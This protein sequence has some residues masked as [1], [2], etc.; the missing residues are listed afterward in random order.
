[1]RDGE[2]PSYYNP[3]EAS[4]LVRLL[5]GLLA[6]TT[7]GGQGVTVQDIG[8]IAT[9]RNQVCFSAT[10]CYTAVICYATYCTCLLFDTVPAHWLS[11]EDPQGASSTGHHLF[12]NEIRMAALCIDRHCFL[13]C[14]QTVTR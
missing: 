11:V 10:V 6:Y 5:Q 9:Y 3:V 14:V 12:H 1:M 7:G 4:T 2:A 13:T 8:V